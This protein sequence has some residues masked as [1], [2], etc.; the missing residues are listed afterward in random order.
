MTGHQHVRKLCEVCDAVI[1]QCWCIGPKE[2]TY[3]RCNMHPSAPCG[4]PTVI[5]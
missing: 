2:T 3:G 4:P 1:L 5:R